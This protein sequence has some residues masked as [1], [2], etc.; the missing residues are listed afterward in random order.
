MRALQVLLVLAGLGAS[1]ARAETERIAFPA[2]GVTLTGVLSVPGGG[3]R[4]P[5]VVAMHGCGG[6]QANGAPMPRDADWAERWR[7]A[8]YIVLQPDS[9]SARGYAGG[10]CRQPNSGATP[11][12][13]A[14][15]AVAAA[16]W[17]AARPDVDAGRMAL[18]GWSHGGTT[19]LHVA[20]RAG[21]PFQRIVA[22]YPGCRGFL[23]S[24]R[25]Q[26]ARPLMILHGEADDWTPIAPCRALSERFGF[27]LNA[28][29]NAHHGFDT[30]DQ[31]LR[32]LRGMAFSARGT[33]QV[34]QGTN[35]E[36]RAAAIRLITRLF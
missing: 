33:G 16:A 20:G 15:D 7:Q 6:F 9:F 31:P 14:D 30:P 18:V 24:Q 28:F 12:I 35:P 32:V 23:A 27:T 22:F 36:A 26:P 25:W 17:L 10:V 34:T 19:S 5:A 13:R 8:G 4:K 21:N 11:A 1:G 2:S 3:G 29:E